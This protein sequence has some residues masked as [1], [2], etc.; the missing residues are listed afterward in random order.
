M[1]SGPATFSVLNTRVE[2]R[3][4]EAVVLE[5]ELRARAL[6]QAQRIEIR[7][8]VPVLAIGLDQAVHALGRDRRGRAF[9]RSGTTVAA[10]AKMLRVN[11]AGG[12]IAGSPAASSDSK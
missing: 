11:V 9:G 7:G 10:P 12:A 3:V 5:R 1:R 2:I 4:G 8:E 6:D